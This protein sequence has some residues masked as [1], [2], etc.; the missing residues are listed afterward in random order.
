ME[1]SV[2][3]DVTQN[4]RTQIYDCFGGTC[5]L[6][7]QCINVFFVE[8]IPFLYIVCRRDMRAGGN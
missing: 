6:C 1:T 3:W 5:R 7:P 4:N 8:F 2:F